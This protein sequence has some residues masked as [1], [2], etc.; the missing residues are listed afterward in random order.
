MKQCGRRRQ[1][2]PSGR[3]QRSR[4][5]VFV[6]MRLCQCLGTTGWRVPPAPAPPRPHLPGV[7]AVHHLGHAV[8]LQ[9]S[10]RLGVG[11][12]GR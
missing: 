4:S 12:Q 5:T 1:V 6:P 2:G 3:A 9:L 7:L 11:L 10:Q 8:A